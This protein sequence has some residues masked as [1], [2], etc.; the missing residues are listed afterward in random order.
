M[1]EFLQTTLS[2]PEGSDARI[3]TLY[4]AEAVPTGRRPPEWIKEAQDR[5][6]RTEAS[7]RWFTSN[8]DALTWCLRDAGPRARVF[9]VDVPTSELDA[10]RVSN[11]NTSCQERW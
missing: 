6:G 7:G 4:R 9:T 3:A 1:A 2:V 11:T 5:F 8:Q 10:L